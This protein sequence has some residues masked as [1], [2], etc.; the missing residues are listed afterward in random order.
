VHFAGGWCG[1]GLAMCV[2]TAQ[3]Y[4][5]VL[6]TGAASGDQRLPWFRTGTT[7]LPSASFRSLALPAYLRAMDLQDRISLTR[8]TGQPD[9]SHPPTVRIPR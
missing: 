2:D 1:H 4:A 5:S 7:G 8:N 6:A 3:R 9:R